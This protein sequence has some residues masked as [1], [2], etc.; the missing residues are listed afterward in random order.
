MSPEIQP[1]Q[2][3][4][5][6]HHGL[7][8]TTFWGKLTILEPRRY[9][10]WGLV[11]ILLNPQDRKLYS[12]TEKRNRKNTGND[13]I[14]PV[15]SP[16]SP[17]YSYRKTG[18]PKEPLKIIK[19]PKTARGGKQELESNSRDAALVLRSGLPSAHPHAFVPLLSVSLSHTLTSD[20]GLGSSY[21]MS[22]GR[23][24]A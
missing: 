7:C 15:F 19:I 23:S 6:F 2:G 8:T 1:V 21:L 14:F 10:F 12:C 24:H 5:G 9:I 18:T 11:C 17:P 20:L 4:C 3:L 13:L 22:L 16:T